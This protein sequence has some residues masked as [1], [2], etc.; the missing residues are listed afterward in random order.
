MATKIKCY[1]G[2]NISMRQQTRQVHSRPRTQSPANHGNRASPR[3]QSVQHAGSSDV[4]K[5]HE[6][7]SRNCAFMRS[8]CAYEIE[9]PH[10]LR[11]SLQFT[12]RVRA[13]LV[14]L[15]DAP[16]ML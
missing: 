10:Y 11:M 13:L 3:A 15:E 2:L 12:D 14:V 9:M 8:N 5:A 1:S 4:E 6:T 16:I 7:N